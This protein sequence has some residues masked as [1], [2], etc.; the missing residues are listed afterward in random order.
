MLNIAIVEDDQRDALQLKACIDRYS[1]ESGRLFTLRLFTD[2]MNITEEPTRFD[3]VFMD[4]EMQHLDGI[5]AAKILRERDA[6][7]CIVFVTNMSKYAVFG[8]EVNALDFIVKPVQ[9]GPF[10]NKLK[11]AI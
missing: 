10:M 3:I 4:I 5:H 7:V 11:R 8:Y 1:Q 6:S 9:Y 2:G